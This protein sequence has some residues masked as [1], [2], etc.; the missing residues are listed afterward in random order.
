MQ[1]AGGAISTDPAVTR[2]WDLPVADAF[3]R[4]Q[5]GPD[6]LTSTEAATR[7]ARVG[8]NVIGTG[9]QTSDLGLL[10]R[11][12]ASPIILILVFA[13]VI[14]GLLGD[15]TDTVIILAII[16]LS[17]LLGFWQER[18]ANRAVAALLAVV[19]V[20]VEVRRGG[21]VVEV[22]STEIVPGDLVVVN[23]G[24]VIP[25]DGLI[26]A[27]NRLLIDEAALTG[28][29][30][31]A[32]KT[33]GV[34]AADAPIAS[35]TNCVFMGTH[36]SSGSG[37]ALIILTGANTEF[38]KVSARLRVRP[39]V[40]SFQRGL[41]AFGYLLVRVMLVLVVAIFVVNVVLARP[42]LDSALFSLA[43]AV[44]LTPQLLPAIVTISLSEGARLMA[45]DRV[46]VKRLDAI[47]D[48]GAMTILCTDKTGT[49]TS[50][51][52]TLEGA[53]GTDGH[54]SARVGRLAYLNAKL[55]TG[56]T[57]PIDDAVVAAGG[58]AA[59][60]G[61]GKRVAELPYDFQR[62][63]LSVLVAGAGVAGA[64]AGPGPD[65]LI[66]KGALDGILAVC[67]TARDAA[68]AAV[69]IA[70]V[71]AKIQAQFS[72][73]SGQG[74]RVLGVSSR[75]LAGRDTV[76]DADESGMTFEGF[77]TFL[78]PPKPDAAATIAELAASGISVRMITGDN[79]LVAAHIGGL[80]GLDAD[81]VLTGDRIDALS[82]PDLAT[83]AAK[84]AIF[85]EIEPTQKERII[86]ALRAS[87]ATVGY[88]GDGINDAPALHA[89]DVGISVDTAVDVAKESAAIVLLDKD[90]G[91]LLHGVRQGRRTFANT[92]KYVFTTT[93]ANFGNMISMAGAAVLLPFLPL[94]PYQILLIN[95]LTDLPAT[96]IATD[97]V[98]PEQL[99][100]PHS[101]DIGFVQSFMIVFG[102]VSSVFDFLTFGVLRL[103]FTADATLFRSGWF[104][105]SVATELAVMFVLRTRRPFFRSQPSVLLTAA[106]LGLLGVTLL[107]IETPIGSLLGLE[108]LPLGVFVALAVITLGY[109][110]TTEVAKW[111]FYRGDRAAAVLAPRGPRP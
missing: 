54:P 35:R 84:T 32:E 64:G 70:P 57:N 12:F 59:S 29:T 53:L 99:D 95:F 17:G 86:R 67:T 39:P 38:G 82:D 109:V 16:A 75:D 3:A 85:A 24:D 42:L 78:D 33:P 36:V 34:V 107:V 7:L 15:A 80:V 11:Q 25:G 56:F 58:P 37:T 9:R 23:A 87:G 20:K 1:G 46:I 13:T 100:R 77:L 8:P 98:D 61:D 96:T 50:G 66:T 60:G 5:S 49:M 43:L 41:T 10:A 97:R 40:T 91:V 71:N 2:F 102:L 105:E 48:F 27:S 103:S 73:L 19:Q 111:F 101:W 69:A 51:D 106:S 28:E 26:V 92:M 83:Q 55:Q 63:R 68:G 4:V 62:R 52:V 72:A 89:A 90:L 22:P 65:L 76:T 81:Q 18:S 74:Y 44:G 30:Y 45:R 110:A 6:G 94:L 47:E 14:A 108:P 79:R 104:L 88:L 31:P 21:T 93:S